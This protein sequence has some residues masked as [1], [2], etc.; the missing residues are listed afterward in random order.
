VIRVVA[1]V[2]ALTDRLGRG[3]S[4]LIFAMTFLTVVVV[5]MRYAFD[6]GAIWLQEPVTYMHAA[7]FLIGAAYA[8]KRDAHVRVDIVYSRLSPRGRTIVDLLGHLLLLVPVS[9]FIL[10]Y[11]VPYVAAS[12]RVMEGSPD[13]G[14]IQGVFLLKTLIPAMAVL[15]LLQGFAEIVRCVRALG[16]KG[17]R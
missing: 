15:L 12:W 8:L 3:V 9:G 17:T 14:G 16:G 11:S 4:W 2:D 13:V 1:F 7:V 10:V 5:L 6:R